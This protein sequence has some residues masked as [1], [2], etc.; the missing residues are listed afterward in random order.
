ME[1]P[2]DPEDFDPKYFHITYMNWIG[3]YMR[4]KMCGYSIYLPLLLLLLLLLFTHSCLIL[5][6]HNDSVL[7]IIRKDNNMFVVKKLGGIFILTVISV[8]NE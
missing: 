1:L 2:F 7:N 3:G 5:I 6:I 8:K 4:K